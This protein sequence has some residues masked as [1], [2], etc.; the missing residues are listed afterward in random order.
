MSLQP[1]VTARGK[2]YQAQ[3][4]EHLLG[5]VRFSDELMQTHL[6]MYG[7]YVTHTNKVLDLLEND[8]LDTYAQREVE[9]R[10]V[11][12][13]NGMRLHELYFNGLVGGS[14]GLN[15]DSALGS[16][17]DKAFKGIDQWEKAFRSL[18]STRGIGWAA[19]VH[20]PSTDRLLH[21]W[22]NEHDAGALA[23]TNTILLMDLFEHAFIRDFGT[24]RG[25][26]MDAYF[27]AVDW[28]VAEKR[29]KQSRLQKNLTQ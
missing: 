27:E 17:V 1:T 21:L 19:L 4:Y 20:D 7:Q 26:Y 8:D 11:W 23:G 10:F 16:A 18:G 12:E 3:D 28:E 5:A 9:R 22:I 14:D 24:D 13:F 2:P 15:K 6:K 29:Y 25:K